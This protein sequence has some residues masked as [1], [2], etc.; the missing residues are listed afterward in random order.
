MQNKFLTRLLFFFLGL[1]LVA[2]GN[3]LSIV[4][5]A[6]NG[7][8]TAAALGLALVTKIPLAVVLFLIGIMIL[9]V[10]VFLAKHWSWLTV[11]GEFLFVLFFSQLIH[12]FVNFLLPLNIA[13]VN[14][15]LRVLL[16]IGGITIVCLGTSFY[17]RANLWMYPT[18]SLTVLLTLRFFPRNVA[19]AQL[20][21]FLMPVL[22]IAV[23]GLSTQQ[24]I[25]VQVGT[26]FSL[27]CNGL[28]IAFF[29]RHICPS[30]TS[31]QA[32]SF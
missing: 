9:A 20:V 1:L 28:L 6:G 11:I 25:G 18:D 17:Q 14:Y 30:L 2:V 24:V 4:S 5:G 15:W 13:A 12:L 8:W 16:A 23:V 27:L 26:V 21:A 32:L 31:N 3:A 22:I 19:R 29:N 7:L 10:N